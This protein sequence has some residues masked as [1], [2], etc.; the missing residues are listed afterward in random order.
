M[1]DTK[2]T[3]TPADLVRV[4]DAALP[5]DQIARNPANQRKTFDEAA[6]DELGASIASIGLLEP[7]V[8]V[9]RDLVDPDDPQRPCRYQLI[10]GE[11]RWRA[12]RKRGIATLPAF[13]YRDVDPKVARVLALVENLQ[14]EQL[15]PMEEAEGYAELIADGLTQAE[16]ADKVSKSRA[17]VSNALRLVELPDAIKDHVR[18]GRLTQKHAEGLLRFREFPRLIAAVADLAIRKGA[19]SADLARGIPFVADLEK[20]KAIIRI[21]QDDLAPAGMQYHGDKTFRVLK[22]LDFV[23]VEK[24]PYAGSDDELFALDPGAWSEW[25]QP[26]IAE[27]EERNRKRLEEHQAE[28]ARRQAAAAGK[29]EP[30]VDLVGQ[31]VETEEA[32][33]ARAPK[34]VDLDA[35]DHGAYVVLSDLQ[36][37]IRR[38]IPVEKIELGR[39]KYMRGTIAPG[40]PVEF[41]RDRAFVEGLQRQASAKKNKIQRAK[42]DVVWDCAL[43]AIKGIKK[44]DSQDLATLAGWIFAGYRADK[45]LDESLREL[46]LEPTSELHRL[47]PIDLLRAILIARLRSDWQRARDAAGEIP[48]DLEDYAGKWEKEYERRKAAEEKEAEKAAAAAKAA[49]AKAGKSAEPKAGKGSKAKASKAAKQPAKGKAAKPARELTIVLWNKAEGGEE[50]A[51]VSSPGGGQR[52]SLQGTASNIEAALGALNA[53]GS[54]VKLDAKFEKK[55]AVKVVGRGKADAV[56]DADDAE[57]SDDEREQIIRRLVMGDSCG[58]LAKVFARSLPTIWSIRRD[59]IAAGK[60]EAKGGAQAAAAGR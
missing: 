25:L 57:I 50:I 41:T 30:A 39:S 4:F 26:R 51:E 35:L 28:L 37:A 18:A 19:S 32:P 31:P 59:A 55:F 8:V 21:D 29:K 1:R 10:I 24:G 9:C 22:A 36:A 12:A 56:V 43:E 13:C 23:R 52:F 3:T 17:R 6:L 48:S 45:F 7:I 44:V 16:I 46:G 38:Q 58:K 49:A 53:D 60:L 54:I 40:Q 15:N 11:R 20:A 47:E 27:H 2:D 5:V 33:A 42:L 34:L 14:R